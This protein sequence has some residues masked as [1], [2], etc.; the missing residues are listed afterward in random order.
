M[1]TLVRLEDNDVC[2][3]RKPSKIRLGGRHFDF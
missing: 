1:H 2:L 3:S